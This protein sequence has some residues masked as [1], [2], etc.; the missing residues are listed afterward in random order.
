[1]INSAFDWC[2]MCSELFQSFSAVDYFISSFADLMTH[3]C[4]VL[5]STESDMCN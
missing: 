2:L 1:M 3:S 5:T 4:A